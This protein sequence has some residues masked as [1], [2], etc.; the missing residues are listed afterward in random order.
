MATPDEVAG[1]AA[2]LCSDMASFV[3]G[4]DI[5]FDGGVLHLRG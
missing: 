3:T 4:A 1:L 2:F 5:P